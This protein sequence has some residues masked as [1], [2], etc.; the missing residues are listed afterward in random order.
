L[1]VE[2]HASLTS[3]S[4]DLLF[5]QVRIRVKELGREGGERERGGGGG[6]ERMKEGESWT[7]RN[8]KR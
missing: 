3:H 4:V 6:R 8:L 7:K 5:F 2:I 1:E